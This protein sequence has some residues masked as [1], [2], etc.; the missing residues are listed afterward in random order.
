MTVPP[1]ATLADT[2]RQLVLRAFASTN[3]D[4]ARTATIV[5]MTAA[6]VRAEIASL[7]NGTASEAQSGATMNG[8]Q[9]APK[10][11][12]SPAPG[13]K[14]VKAPVKAVASPAKV[15]PKKR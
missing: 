6:D 1:G 4:Y 9:H 12:E 7:L 10:A 3:G 14:S 2:R 13:G 5:G 15:K 11:F 8:A